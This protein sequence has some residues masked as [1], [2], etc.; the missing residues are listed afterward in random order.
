MDSPRKRFEL[1]PKAEAN[2]NF[3]VESMVVAHDAR[4]VGLD[5]PNRRLFAPAR[6]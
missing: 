5:E 1:P 2:G 4:K 6:F 3:L